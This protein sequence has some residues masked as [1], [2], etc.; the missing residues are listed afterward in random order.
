MPASELEAAIVDVNKCV[1]MCNHIRQKH[2]LKSQSAKMADKLADLFFIRGSALGQQRCET[3]L[4][5]ERG[6][7]PL[8]AFGTVPPTSQPR[9]APEI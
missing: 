1:H 5:L 4:Q 7:L 8:A 6:R 2:F 3:S 9:S